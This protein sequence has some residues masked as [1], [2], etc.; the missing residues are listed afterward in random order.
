[1]SKRLLN[2][3]IH[4][5]GEFTRENIAMVKN[6]AIELTEA[7]RRI[8][9]LRIE[10]VR[11]TVEGNS[12]LLKSLLKNVEETTA[13]IEQESTPLQSKMKK[14]AETNVA[15]FEITSR[16]ISG[17]SEVFGQSFSAYGAMINKIGRWGAS[18]PVERRVSAELIAFPERREALLA[19][20]VV[21]G[22]YPAAGRKQH[23]A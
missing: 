11:A 23:A 20:N 12:R 21:S 5:P 15:W 9:A 4:T 18:V 16:S 6:V 2:S 8:H 7:S 22:V 19:K 1:M 14:I 13:I 3:P 17:M 10:V